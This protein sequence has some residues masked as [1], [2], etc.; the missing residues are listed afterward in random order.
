M[1]SPKVS[2]LIPTY[3]QPDYLRQALGSIASQ[4]YKDI[5]VVITDDSED[6]SI[7]FV[8]DEFSTK[9]DI[10]YFKNP[11]RRGSPDNWNEAIAQSSGEYIKFLHHDD[12]FTTEDSLQAY[13]KALDE[14]PQVNFAFSCTNVCDTNRNI[15]RTHCPTEREL[16]RL[17]KNPINLFPNNNFV[18]APSAT[19]YRRKVNK[20]FDKNLKW[21]VD[22][23]FYISI[24]KEDPAFVFIPKNAVCCTYGA[25][26]Q[27]TM[28][29]QNNK[30]VELFEWIYLFTKIDNSVIPNFFHIFF[31]WSILLK[32]EVTTVKEIHESGINSVPVW[33]PF[34]I[35]LDRILMPGARIIKRLIQKR[36][37]L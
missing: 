18:G 8:V 14:T 25:S 26:G 29:C 3:N 7:L 17:R 30:K 33:M 1:T 24:L 20:L 23:D 36:H 37:K 2:I 13:V 12:W 21:V 32:H 27:V 28:G 4:T 35:A 6:N 15:I 22:I 16:R 11:V 31:I 19:I 5:E 10:K 9:L 34:L